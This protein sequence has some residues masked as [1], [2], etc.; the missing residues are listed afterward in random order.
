MKRTMEFTLIELLV[1]VAIIA[2]LASMLLPALNQ[3]RQ[4]ALAIKCVGNLKQVG[5]ILMFYA[6]DNARVLPTATTNGPKLLTWAPYLIMQGY[7]GK[8]SSDTNSIYKVS[9]ANVFVCPSYNPFRFDPTMT[10]E[11][12][13]Y[14]LNVVVYYSKDGSVKQTWSNYTAIEL[15]R[16]PEPSREAIIADSLVLNATSNIQ[17]CWFCP[18]SAQSTACRIHARH[19]QR[20]N[21]LMGDM[22]VEN[23]GTYELKNKYIQ[24]YRHYTEKGVL[25]P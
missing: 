16:L 25:I 14:G 5:V 8:S 11:A 15:N 18:S 4:K 12:P 24:P 20:A 17:K 13:T 10:G 7:L 6:D 2:I 23:A 3:A 21:L 22:H 1:V 19:S 9:G